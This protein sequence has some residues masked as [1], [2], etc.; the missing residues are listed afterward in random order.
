MKLLKVTLVA[1]ALSAFAMSAQA[2]DSKLYV[3][4]GVQTLEFDT[5]SLVGRVGYNFARNYGVEVEGAVGISGTEE[6][7]IE[8]DTPW[9]VGAYFVSSVPITENFEIIGRIGYAN[10]NIELE[11]LDESADTN[12]DGFATGGGIQYN[13]DKSNGV[14]LDYTNLFT[15]SG[16][17]DVLDVTYVRRF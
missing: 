15:G 2:Q 13:F 10:I 12:V 1:T 8:F 14:R 4:A 17:A 6:D 11:S 5:V 9:S 16:N 7:D 3:N